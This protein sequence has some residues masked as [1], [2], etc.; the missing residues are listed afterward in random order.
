MQK[1]GSKI[2]EKMSC[3][4]LANPLPTPCVIWWHCPAKIGSKLM[5]L[6]SEF[7][8]LFVLSLGQSLSPVPNFFHPYYCYFLPKFVPPGYISAI[9]DLIFA[10]VCPIYIFYFVPKFV[11]FAKVCSSLQKFVP[12]CQILLKISW[13]FWKNLLIISTKGAS[14]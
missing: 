14:Q 7:G 10:K 12:P 5:N 3:D 9:F 13:Y 2:L 1:Y 8:K 6:N 11:L 4:T